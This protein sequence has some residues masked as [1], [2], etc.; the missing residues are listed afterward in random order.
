MAVPAWEGH[1]QHCHHCPEHFTGEP[2]SRDVVLVKV[3]QQMACDWLWLGCGRYS[4]FKTGTHSSQ[5]GKQSW[6]QGSEAALERGGCPQTSSLSLLGEQ[7][8]RVALLRVSG[9]FPTSGGLGWAGDI[10]PSME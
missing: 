10:L 9:G 7:G 8:G 6:E 2:L 4:R 1:S 5:G 3:W